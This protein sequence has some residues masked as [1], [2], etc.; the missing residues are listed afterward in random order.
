M[1]DVGLLSAKDDNVLL[2]DKTLLLEIET[3]KVRGEPNFTV[4]VHIR[5]IIDKQQK[6]NRTEY[7][8]RRNLIL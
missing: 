5:N 4:N 6:Q 2:D 7:Q 1:F 3:S 8:S